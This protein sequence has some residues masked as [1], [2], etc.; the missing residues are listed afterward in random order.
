VPV[1]IMSIAAANLYTRNIHR[2]FINANPTDKQEAQMAVVLGVDT[3]RF[4]DWALL[5]GWAIGMAARRDITPVTPI[6]SFVRVNATTTEAPAAVGKRH[7]R[8]TAAP[9]KFV[10]LSAVP[11]GSIT[12]ASAQS[13]RLASIRSAGSSGRTRS[14]ISATGGS[15]GSAVI[16]RRCAP[17][18]AGAAHHDHHRRRAALL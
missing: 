13:C 9:V 10:E 6:I 5:I 14:S 8:A 4:N 15:A 1:A 3:R 12:G 17:V 7:F 18:R 16:V 11:S 2:E